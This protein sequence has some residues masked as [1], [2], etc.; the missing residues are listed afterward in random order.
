M[1]FAAKQTNSDIRYSSATVQDVFLHTIYQ[2]LG[3]KYKDICSELKPL[4]SNHTITDEAILRSVTIITSDENERVRRLGPVTRVK[5]STASCSQLESES[6]REFNEIPEQKKNDPIK[7]LTARID[8]LTSMVDSMRQSKQLARPEHTGQYSM[9]K[10]LSQRGV[11]SHGCPKCVEAGHN[12]T[13]CFLCG[14]A[15]HLARGCLQKHRLHGNEKRP[16][17]RDDQ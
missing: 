6:V 17:R 10:P 9:S 8:A 13:H 14:E 1:I 4:L 15:G 16:L 12:C 2:G 3:H 11:K 5:Q 7:Q